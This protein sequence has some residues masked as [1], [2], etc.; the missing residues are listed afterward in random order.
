MCNTILCNFAK[1]HPFLL[2]NLHKTSISIY[3]PRGL[4]LLLSLISSSKN[5]PGKSEIEP[6]SEEEFIYPIKNGCVIGNSDY[7]VTLEMGIQS[8]LSQVLLLTP[9]DKV[10]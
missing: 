1:Y 9:A 3:L 7:T 10:S 6:V 2:G 5:W 8:K 4:L